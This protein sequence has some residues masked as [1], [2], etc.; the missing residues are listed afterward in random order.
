MN[1]VLSIAAG[2]A[3]GAVGRHYVAISV[4][5]WL[6]DVFPFGTLTVNVLG[7]LAMGLLVE[8]MTLTWSP[9]QELRAFMTVGFMGGFTTFSAFSMETILLVQRGESLTAVGYVL[10]SVV[11]SVG[12]FFLGMAVLRQLLT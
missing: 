5:R 4:A 6:G 8:L 1:L 9:G 12:A 3:L 10:A 2:G 11:L 7:S